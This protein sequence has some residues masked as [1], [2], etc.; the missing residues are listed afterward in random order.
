[1]AHVLRALQA[2]AGVSRELAGVLNDAAAQH[3]DPAEAGPGPPR[4]R[5]AL[6]EASPRLV[7]PGQKRAWR[8]MMQ[9]NDLSSA[10]AG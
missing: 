10:E 1:M 2:D 4:E 7:Y 6:D 5:A 3:Y 9:S 8:D